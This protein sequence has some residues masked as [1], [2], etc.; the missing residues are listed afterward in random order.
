MLLSVL[1]M[2]AL[3]IGK[4]KGTID[5][6]K[7][8]YNDKGKLVFINPTPLFQKAPKG[9]SEIKVDR[10]FYIDTKQM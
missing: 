3:K 10:N 4:E 1:M 6:Y 7:Y 9:I 8:Y 2:I 5:E